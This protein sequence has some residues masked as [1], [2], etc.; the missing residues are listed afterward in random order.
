MKQVW[1][2]DKS[3]F[4][5]DGIAQ[6]KNQYYWALYRDAVTPTETQL[7]PI[8][9]MV[10]AAVSEKGSIGPYLF[11]KNSKNMP[12]NRQSYQECAI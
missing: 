6:K 4:Y 10:W 1:F 2:S 3:W 11:H 9:V 5:A 12:V 8:K 7:V